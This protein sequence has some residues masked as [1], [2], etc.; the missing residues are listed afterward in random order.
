MDHAQCRYRTYDPRVLNQTPLGH[1]RSPKQVACCTYNISFLVI[2]ARK[3]SIR[4]YQPSGVIEYSSLLLCWVRMETYGFVMAVDW[5]I[6][7]GMKPMCHS[8]SCHSLHLTLTINQFLWLMLFDPVGVT[9][10]M[11]FKNSSLNIFGLCYIFKLKREHLKITKQTI[12]CGYFAR[13]MDMHCV[14]NLFS[15]STESQ[16]STWLL[17]RTEDIALAVDKDAME[18]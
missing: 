1:D 6:L 18:S 15:N 4:G 2:L 12:Y 7:P 3:V 8:F 17:I 5:N 10:Q 9:T 13:I 16:L 11:N 14:A